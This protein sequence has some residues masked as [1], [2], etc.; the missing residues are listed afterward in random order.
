[1]MMTYAAFTRHLTRH[2]LFLDK[3]KSYS[4]IPLV[5]YSAIPLLGVSNR[6][7]G[8]GNGTVEWKMEW[9]GERT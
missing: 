6:W 2:I 4:V 9:N 3:S 7:N 8:I 1:M 5:H